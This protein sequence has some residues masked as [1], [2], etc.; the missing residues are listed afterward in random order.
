M[1]H[2]H[3]SL[4]QAHVALSFTH[5]TPTC[6]TLVYILHSVLSWTLTHPSLGVFLYPWHTLTALPHTLTA[7]SHAAPF[8]TLT[9]LSHAA[10][11]HTLLHSH[12]RVSS[13]LLRFTPGGVI[14]VLLG[15]ATAHWSSRAPPL[16]RRGICS[17]T[18]PAGGR[19]GAGWG[20]AGVHRV[21]QGHGINSK[22]TADLG[23]FYCNT[24]SEGL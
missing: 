10:P 1:L 12:T 8:H 15:S 2:S 9:A 18:G 4:S 7:L 16:G 5:N 6:C 23:G 13:L 3:V 17:V 19:L 11:F 21:G 24:S 22:Q 14:P 20:P